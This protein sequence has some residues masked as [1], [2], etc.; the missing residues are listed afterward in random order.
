MLD[1]VKAG[2]L[3]FIELGCDAHEGEMR[4]MVGLGTPL[5]DC[6]AGSEEMLVEVRWYARTLW[7]H[8][9]QHQWGS[10]PFFEF[11]R[12]PANPRLRTTHPRSVV[13]TAFRRR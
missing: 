8:K 5:G 9:Q 3:Y 12:D 6:C 2:E 7:V 10:N 11:A 4:V 13:G 1:T